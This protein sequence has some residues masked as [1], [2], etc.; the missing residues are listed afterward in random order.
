MCLYTELEAVE[1]INVF[2]PRFPVAPTP[3]F[4]MLLS[5]FPPLSF[6]SMLCKKISTISI[7]PSPA[8]IAYLLYFCFHYHL[9]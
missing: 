6:I 8:L 5:T 9:Y 4:Q 7:I 2:G 3:S 1:V